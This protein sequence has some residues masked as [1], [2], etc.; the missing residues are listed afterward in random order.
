[1]WLESCWEEHFF[2]E[3]TYINKVATH[4][5][6]SVTVALVTCRLLKG[7][8]NRLIVLMKTQTDLKV[9]TKSIPRATDLLS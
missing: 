6:L 9:F 4:L 8:E 3:K 1:M 7:R 2:L 5:L